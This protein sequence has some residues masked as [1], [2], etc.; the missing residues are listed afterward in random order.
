MRKF[1]PSKISRYTVVIWSLHDV[2]KADCENIAEHVASAFNLGRLALPVTF[3]AALQLGVAI[4]SRC[5][6]L[7]GVHVATDNLHECV[8]CMVSGQFKQASTHTQSSHSSVGLAQVCLNYS[9]MI[10]QPILHC[11]YVC[12]CLFVWTNHSPYIFNSQFSI[13]TQLFFVWT[14]NS[15][16]TI[17]SFSQHLEW[18]LH[19]LSGQM[20]LVISCWNWVLTMWWTMY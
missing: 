7:T 13:A 4:H 18:L 9:L 2:N 15:Q 11:A 6:G 5:Y 1:A 17:R 8:K 10:Q 19:L 3:M 12:V 16:L 14:I 20:F